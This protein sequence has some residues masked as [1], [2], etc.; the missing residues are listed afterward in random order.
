ML[1]NMALAVL[2]IPDIEQAFDSLERFALE[3][4]RRAVLDQLK[5]RAAVKQHDSPV[6]R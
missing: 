3:K 2:D 5:A 4:R 6:R 1:F